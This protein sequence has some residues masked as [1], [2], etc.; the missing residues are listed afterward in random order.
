MIG[1]EFSRHFCFC[2]EEDS[3]LSDETVSSKNLPQGLS[4]QFSENSV[5]WVF[6]SVICVWT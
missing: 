2:D 5:K 4:E 3:G 6:L 1:D